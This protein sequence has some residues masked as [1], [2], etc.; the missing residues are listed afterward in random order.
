[1]G[2]HFLFF[3]EAMTK[4]LD[5][6]TAAVSLII[7]AAILAARCSGMNL[8]LDGRVEALVQRPRQRSKE[9]MDQGLFS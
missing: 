8:V 2:F 6:I 1:M 7:K 5:T 9:R 4:N 3:H